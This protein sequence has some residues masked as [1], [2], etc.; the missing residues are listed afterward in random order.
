MVV[1][2]RQF[3]PNILEMMDR[4]D[5]DPGRVRDDLKNLR[6]INKL[7]GGFSAV[8]RNILPLMNSDG[9]LISVVN[10][11][12]N[13]ANVAM[14]TTPELAQLA[15]TDLQSFLNKT[16]FT[17]VRAGKRLDNMQPLGDIAVASPISLMVSRS[18]HRSAFLIGDAHRTVEPFTGE[19]VFLALE[20][21][22]STALRLLNVR[23]SPVHMRS[24][25]ADGRLWVNRIYSHVLRYRWLADRLVASG[26]R[27]PIL[28]PLAA[29]PILSRRVVS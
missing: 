6:T 27:I 16:F 4:S 29:R 26:E 22:L 17:N 19:G 8:R 3:D 10:V 11:D 7:F 25:P 28:T 1:P 13:R 5:A 2:P 14:V 15:K 21:G 23:Y 20:D 18:S 9:G 24:H 12:E